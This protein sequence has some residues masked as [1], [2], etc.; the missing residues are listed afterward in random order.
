MVQSSVTDTHHRSAN[1]ERTACQRVGS[2]T[3]ITLLSSLVDK[4][5]R[6]YTSLWDSGNT[7][8]VKCWE[9]LKSALISAL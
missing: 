2:T 6:Q 9:D 8:L 7:N 5:D 3:G 1:S 4:L